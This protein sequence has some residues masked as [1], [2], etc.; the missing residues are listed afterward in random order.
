LIAHLQDGAA[1]PALSYPLNG[2]PRKTQMGADL[3]N[4]VTKWEG[5]ALLVNTIVSGPAS[6]SIMERWERSRDGNRLTVERTIVRPSGESESVL[7]YVNANAPAPAQ[8]SSTRPESAVMPPPRPSAPQPLH[9][10]TPDAPDSATYA[11]AAGTRILLRLTNS[12]N[13]KHSRPGDRVYLDTAV[14]V[15]V[16]GRLVIPRGSYVTGTITEAQR[17][18]R[19]KGKS[20][21]DL[22]FDSITLQNGVVRDFHS[23]AGSVDSRGNLDRDEGRIRGESNKGGDART[24]AGTTAAGAGIG[25]I[26]GAASG[27]L[28]AG[29]GIG[30]AAG[31]LAGLA[32]V[33]G[34]RGPD[35]V[36]PQGTTMELVLDRELVFTAAELG[37]RI[38]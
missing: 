22:R 35:V 6:Y 32:G 23:R 11:V 7:A 15:F 3:M 36:I 37:G 14:P 9:P 25:S 27:H 5:S 30:S 21:L 38:Q 12:V 4:V 1:L 29:L 13:T 24:V 2:R 19:V 10:R 33:L 20:A 31:A 18:G 34:S 26:A 16:N 28:G 8:V 17:A